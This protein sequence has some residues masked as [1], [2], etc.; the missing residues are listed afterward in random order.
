[1]NNELFHH[2]ILGMKWGKRN[3]PPYPLSAG[4]H[5]TSEKKAGWEKSLDKKTAEPHNESTSSSDGF[6]LTDKQKKALKTGAIV[7]GSVLAAYG[8]YRLGQSGAFDSLISAGQNAVGKSIL[9]ANSPIDLE[10]AVTN[11]VDSKTG[12]KLLASKESVSEAIAHVN[13]TGSDDNCYNVVVAT[14]ARLCGLDVTAKGDTHAG[15]GMEFDDIC[16]VFKNVKSVNVES[17]SMANVAKLIQERFSDGDVG[18]IAVNWN[19]SLI[20]KDKLGKY[21]GHTFNWIVERGQVQFMDGQDNLQGEHFA[22]L[23]DKYF[24]HGQPVQVA[25][26]GNVT[27]GLEDV[28]VDAIKKMVNG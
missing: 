9:D 4:K 16:K 13:P 14:V 2:G 18:A 10:C 23:V 26:F 21:S 3:G 22:K 12:F 17:P 5:S 1:M 25:K 8:A 28:N 24:D 6:S 20:S 15:E 11:G 27:S 19:T 7:A